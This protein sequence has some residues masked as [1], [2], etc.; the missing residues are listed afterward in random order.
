MHLYV[1]TAMLVCSALSTD[2]KTRRMMITNPNRSF[3]FIY[4]YTENSFVY[5]S[6]TKKGVLN[7]EVAFVT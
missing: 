3:M 6:D 5:Y 7:K 1:F 4:T 2:N